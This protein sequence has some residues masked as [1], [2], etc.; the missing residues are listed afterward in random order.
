MPTRSDRDPM[1]LKAMKVLE[2]FAGNQT[3]FTFHEIASK[4][5]GSSDEVLVITRTL[6]AE[7]FLDRDF[8]K[9]S[10]RVGHRIFQLGMRYASEM[11]LAQTIRPY[12][13]SLS[14]RFHE[15]VNVG[16]QVGSGVVVAL[17][18]D[19][20][21]PFMVLPGPG[22][23]IPIHSSAMGKALLAYQDESHVRYTLAATDMLAF[24]AKTEQEIDG[25]VSRLDAV[26]ERGYAVDDEETLKGVCSIA[27]PILD[28][29]SVAIAAISLSGPRAH[30]DPANA[31][32]L[33]AVRETALQISRLLGFPYTD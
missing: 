23:S 25:F 12:A 20:E 26:R 21:H 4:L 11:E 15:A 16:F 29:R 19:P 28:H 5:G 7:G 18:I 8:E 31:E 32:I 33:D 3:R 13:I 27:A 2:L 17:R 30:I 1:I 24:T 6:E 22:T 9:N 14:N 10:Y